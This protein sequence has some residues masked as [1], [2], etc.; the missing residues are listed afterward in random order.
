VRRQGGETRAMRT[1]HRSHRT[2]DVIARQLTQSNNG[3]LSAVLKSQR[4]RPRLRAPPRVMLLFRM[5]PLYVK[6]LRARPERSQALSA[7]VETIV[8]STASDR[9]VRSVR[10]ATGR[11]LTYALGTTSKCDTSQAV[12]RRLATWEGVP[13]LGT[14]TEHITFPHSDSCNLQKGG[15]A[16]RYAP[17]PW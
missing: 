3:W 10:A 17:D 11:E 6:R 9:L 13:N 15:L 7:L 16:R 4:P 12:P 14:S 1:A 2:P 5:V 8:V